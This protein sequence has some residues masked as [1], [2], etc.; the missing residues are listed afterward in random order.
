MVTLAM[1]EQEPGAFEVTTKATLSGVYH[2]RI[3]ANG[4]TFRGSPFTR[5]QLATAAV[6]TGGDQPYQPPRRDP[7]D[8]WCEWLS[9]LLG[10]HHLSPEL[11]KRLAREGIDLKSIRRCLDEHCHGSR[12][13]RE[14]P[15]NRG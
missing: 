3:V 12:R 4:A 8:A 11:E 15:M 14:V 10:Q 7:A 6:W 13:G 2:A 1:P 9:C 5:E